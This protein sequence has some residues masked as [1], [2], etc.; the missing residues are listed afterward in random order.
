MST[1]LH[2]K[3]L[4]LVCLICGGIASSLLMLP[5]MI[6]VVQTNGQ[7]NGILQRGKHFFTYLWCDGFQGTWP[8][9]SEFPSSTAYITNVVSRGAI[10]H[11][12]YSLFSAPGITAYRGTNAGWFKAENNAWCVVADLSDNA[13]DNTPFL[14]TRNLNVSSLAE[15]KGKVGDQLSDEPPF[16]RKGVVI[17]SKGGAANIVKP[18]MLWSDF[19][20]GQTF[21]NRVLRP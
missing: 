19:L 11:D 12:D 13:A 5:T 6:D 16:G 4:W 18:D 15:L 21:T 2:S 1:P 3:R 7:M 10:R 14:I 8:D 9:S 17:I 20:G